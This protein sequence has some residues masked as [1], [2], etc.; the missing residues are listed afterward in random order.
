MVEKHS[1]VEV[2]RFN[3]ST[4]NYDWIQIDSDEI[5]PGDIVKIYTNSLIPADI[6]LMN[7]KCI[8]N[9]AMLSGESVPLIKENILN[10]TTI[11]ETKNVIF[12]GS[13]ILYA[14]SKNNAF[15]EGLVIYTN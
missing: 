1:T 2:K 4:N 8:V 10:E 7:G 3:I 9:E 14:S 15:A 12:Y 6:V 13:S 5:V 11:D